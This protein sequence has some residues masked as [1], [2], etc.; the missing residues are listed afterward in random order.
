MN[1]INVIRPYR[2]LGMWV[3]DDEK[4]NVVQEPF[5]GGADS[6]L[7][8]WTADIPG[9]ADGFSLVFSSEPFPGFQHELFWVRPEM[10]GNIYRVGEGGPEGWLCPVL[11]RYFEVPPQRLYAAVRQS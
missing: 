9:A 1:A 7:D 11:L 8:V 5:V 4:R 6:I 3:F 10:S 2:A